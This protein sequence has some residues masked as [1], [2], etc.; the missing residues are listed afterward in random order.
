[1]TSVIIIDAA[2]VVGSTPDGWWRDRPRATR[3]LRDRLAPLADR[4]LPRWPHPPPAE[5]ILVT[6]GRARGVESSD[7]VTVVAAPGSGDDTIVDLVTQYAARPVVV[8][9][10]DRGL[11]QRVSDAGAHT[12]PASTVAPE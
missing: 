5:V 3:R 11:R 9:T 2:N 10:S 1:M 7:T 12:L 4:G 8:I 6:E